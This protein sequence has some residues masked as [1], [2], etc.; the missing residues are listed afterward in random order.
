LRNE[1]VFLKIHE[2]SIGMAV[3]LGLLALGSIFSGYFFKDFFV[4]LGTPF[5]KNSILVLEKNIVL[6][7]AEFVP[8]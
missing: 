7:E 3:P 4:G 6:V 1:K 5:F 2:V 8:L